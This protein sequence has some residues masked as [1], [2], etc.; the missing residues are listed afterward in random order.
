MAGIPS[1]VVGRGDN[2]DVKVHRLKGT[3][4]KWDQGLGSRNQVPGIRNKEGFELW[5][6]IH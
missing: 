2:Q 6:S 4:A 3:T 5:G 1:T